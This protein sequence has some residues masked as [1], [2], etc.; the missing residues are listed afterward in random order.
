MTKESWETSEVDTG[1]TPKKKFVE[2]QKITGANM[3]RWRCVDSRAHPQSIG[4][5]WMTIKGSE[6]ES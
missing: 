3:R 5:E 6:Y 2:E 1:G 4:L